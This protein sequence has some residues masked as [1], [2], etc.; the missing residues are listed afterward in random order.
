MPCMS[1][2]VRLALLP[3]LNQYLKKENYNKDG[4]VTLEGLSPV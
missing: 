3:S 2:F 4:C 1:L